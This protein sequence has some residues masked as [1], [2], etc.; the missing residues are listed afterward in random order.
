MTANNRHKLTL[1]EVTSLV[2]T[3]GLQDLTEAAW[4]AFE[5]GVKALSNQ[6]LDY[7]SKTD[8]NLG[9]VKP[10]AI[11]KLSRMSPGEP[12]GPFFMLEVGLPLS[13][14]VSYFMH[15]IPKEGRPVR[16]AFLKDGEQQVGLCLQLTNGNSEVFVLRK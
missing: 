1:E 7:Y 2:Q 14:E 3:A 13:L 16:F 9:Y 12:S 6:V 4:P 15:A 5:A 11:K 8:G 10:L